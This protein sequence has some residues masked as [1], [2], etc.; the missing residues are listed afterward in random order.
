MG[1]SGDQTPKYDGLRAVDNGNGN[2]T[3]NVDFY[4]L[5]GMDD[6]LQ[7]MT[8]LGTQMGNDA[9]AIAKTIS[10]TDSHQA[11]SYGV[12]SFQ[13]PDSTSATLTQTQVD[14]I[15]FGDSAFVGFKP[16]VDAATEE[17]L[18]AAAQQLGYSHVMLDS[19]LGGDAK[20][21]PHA[22]AYTAPL[23]VEAKKTGFAVAAVGHRHALHDRHDQRAG[24]DHAVG[25]RR[26]Q[27]RGGDHHAERRHR[28]GVDD[29]VHG[30]RE[31]DLR[32]HGHRQ[33]R[34]HGDDP[35]DGL[36]HRALRSRRDG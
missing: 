14:S 22:A 27:R 11:I 4:T 15:R 30:D 12:A 6:I 33:R 16:E 36:E 8:T 10:P 20:Y 9:I 7:H 5:T 24:D 3:D 34:Q 18:Q 26:P 23:T 21:M 32:L 17:Q 1:A 29:D 35:G 31:R 13:W 19:F 28:A 2:V 25:L